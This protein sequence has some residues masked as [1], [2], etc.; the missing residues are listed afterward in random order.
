MK[1]A[2]ERPRLPRLAEDEGAPQASSDL[3]ITDAYRF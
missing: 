3:S 1:K 2:G